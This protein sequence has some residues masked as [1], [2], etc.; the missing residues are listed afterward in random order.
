MTRLRAYAVRSGAACLV[1]LV[2]SCNSGASDV[3]CLQSVDPA[4]SVE[5]RDSTTLKGLAAQSV[6]TVVDGGYS[7]TLRFVPDPDSAFRE[8]PD[9]RAG[10]YNLTIT[11]VGYQAWNLN[12]IQVKR[13]V[14]HVE[15]VRLQAF[16]RP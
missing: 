16:L 8:G 6:A 11:A 5:I 9:E 15:T 14:C 10:T 2:S 4:I 12:A 3:A 1:G 7:D 13:G